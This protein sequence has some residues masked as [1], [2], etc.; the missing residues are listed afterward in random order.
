MIHIQSSL[1]SPQRIQNQTNFMQIGLATSEEIQN[2][3]ERSY[4][5]DGQFLEIGEVKKADTINYRTFKPEKDGLFCERI[6]GPVSDWLCSCGQYSGV[7]GGMNGPSSK[8]SSKLENSVSHSWTS[9]NFSNSLADSN[10]G[11][12]SSQNK[13]GFGIGNQQNKT[14]MLWHALRGSRSR[15]KFSGIQFDSK[16]WPNSLEIKDHEAGFLLSESFI[17][18]DEN[19]SFSSSLNQSGATS[20]LPQCRICPNCQVELTLSRI[21]RYRMGYIGLACPVTHIWF[22]NS[23]PNLFSV[24]M[25]MPTKYVKKINYYKGYSPSQK[26][27]MNPCFGPGGDFFDTEWEFLHR[28]FGASLNQSLQAI[29]S[30]PASQSQKRTWTNSK[31]G[32]VTSFSGEATERSLDVKTLFSHQ[33]SPAEPGFLSGSAGIPLFPNQA[34][35]RFS[36]SSQHFPEYPSWLENTGANGFFHHFQNRN[37]EKEF[38]KLHYEL[39]E[40]P[41]L[42]SPANLDESDAFAL[43]NRL[44]KNQKMSLRAPLEHHIEF[45]LKRRK[46][47]VRK[48]K[49]LNILRTAGHFPFQNLDMVT[50]SPSQA[51]MNPGFAGKN[52]NEKEFSKGNRT[53]QKVGGNQ[54]FLFTNIPVLPPELRPIV[55]LNAGQL[56]S[57]DV[58]D[59]YRRLISRNN[60]L[61]YYLNSCGPHLVEFLVRSEQH[62]VQLSVDA[63]FENGKTGGMGRTG[64]EASLEGSRDSSGKKQIYKSLSDRIGGKQGR[65]RQNLLGK[66]VDYSGRSVI[67]VGPKLKLNQCGLPIEMATELFQAFLIRHILELQLAKT[68]RGAKNILRYNQNLTRQLLQN[69]VQSHPILLNRAPTLHRLGIQAFQP[70]LVSG[71][72]IQLHPLV[73]T[74]FNADFDGDQM[75]VHLPLS[76]KARVEARLLMLAN[77]NWFS[78]ATG[79]PSILPSQDMVLGF[80]Y[81]TIENPISTKKNKK[82]NRQMTTFDLVKESTNQSVPDLPERL[83]LTQT[84]FPVFS[85]LVDVLQDYESGT[86]SLHSQV[87][88]NIE[89]SNQ[90]SFIQ[91]SGSFN[92]NPPPYRKKNSGEGMQTSRHNAFSF[93]NLSS[94]SLNHEIPAESGF[95][96]SLNSSLAGKSLGESQAFAQKDSTPLTSPK[97]GGYSDSSGRP[98]KNP[99]EPLFVRISNSARTMKL[100]SSYKWCE[101]SKENRTRFWIRT[102]PGRILVNQLI[103]SA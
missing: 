83:D 51:S 93:S 92:T 32:S 10:L 103:L 34:E 56:A 4:F 84:K 57:S 69:V 41:Q 5:L 81:L 96:Q 78:P 6:F 50:E 68:I 13:N 44:Q 99:D 30:F 100:F 52:G 53:S 2:W 71:R 15:R 45:L 31:L 66:R 49:L 25:K 58:N 95:K 42:I 82:M 12:S 24:L 64:K 17:R 26:S 79:Q 98:G 80:Y 86:L 1:L 19:E 59:L 101:D 102:T 67:V 29:L 11:K 21:R 48:M 60:R 47:K 85:S 97:T 16:R 74:A 63:L 77:T 88:V 65:F 28:W 39:R 3:S 76:A 40:S 91:I 73:C 61:K 36:S 23:R 7:P 89:K 37:W 94:S 90:E 62:L 87:W 46:K 18:S 72:A 38:Q 8:G 70:K 22:L 35:S 20:E 33:D 55:Q 9:G 14:K 75:A 54:A 27:Y 43:T